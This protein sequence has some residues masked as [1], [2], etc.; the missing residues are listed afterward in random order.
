[1]DTAHIAKLVFDLLVVLLAGLTAGIICKRFGISVLVGY[2]VVGAML[3]FNGRGLIADEHSQLHYMAEAGALLLLFSIGLEFSLSELIKLSRY[4]FIGGSLQMIFVAAPVTVV[5]LVAGVSWKAAVLIG[6]AAALRSTVLVYKAL[7]EYGQTET[8]HGRGAVAMLLFQDA[9]LV[10]LVLLVPLL[11]G[12]GPTNIPGILLTL[13][14]KSLLL[15]AAV[16]LLRFIATYGVVPLLASLRSTE[17][18]VLFA[19]TVLGGGGIAAHYLGLPPALGAFAAGLVLGQNRLTAQIDALVLPYRETFAAVF[20]VSIGSL[21]RFDILY[22]Q[23]LL[24]LGGLL[25][26]VLWKAAAAGLALRVAGLSWR[27]SAGTAVGLAQLGEFAFLLLSAGATTGLIAPDVFHLMLFIALGSLV[28]TPLLLKIGLGWTDPLLQEELEG[29][30]RLERGGPN[31][32]R[33][34]VVGMGPI[35]SQGA[36]RLETSGMA[37]VLVD[38]SPV[39]LY[40]FAQ[41]GFVTVAGDATEP[42]VLARAAAGQCILAVITVPKDQAAKQIVMAV[43]RASPRCRILVRCR[44]RASIAALKKAGADAVVSEEAEASAGL[45]RLLEGL[46]DP[47]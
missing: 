13:A 40:R 5:V 15:I 22:Q 19:L 31:V 17:L 37:A 26:A 14:G 41:E 29:G 24:C 45:L 7:A 46:D 21:M 1:V 32:R 36:S 2:I 30:L 10:P 18:V 47:R 39:N 38:L 27:A 16:A 28:L 23:P 25:A 42:P 20:F 43:R 3:G 8:P 6:P 44:Y 4:F 11:T 33:A 35:G 9:A 12:Q 34:L